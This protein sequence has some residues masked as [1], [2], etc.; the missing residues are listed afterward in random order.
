MRCVLYVHGMGG[1]PSEAESF[2]KDCPGFEVVGAEY[3]GSFPAKARDGI[4]LAYDAV[5]VKHEAVY[6]IANSIGAYFTMLALHG[7]DVAKALFISP[8]LDMERLILDMMRRAGVSEDELRQKG[9]ILTASGETLSWE[10]LRFV[11][12]NPVT[13]CV[14][15]E[16]L[17]AGHDSITSRETVDEFVSKHDAGLTVMDD[18]EHWFHTEEQVAFLDGWIRRIIS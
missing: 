13:W 6:V 17:Y 14:P 10:Y 2:R 1:S 8:V 7:R 18:G 15:T 5:C 3:D 11:R 4:R 12:E 16:I 9:E